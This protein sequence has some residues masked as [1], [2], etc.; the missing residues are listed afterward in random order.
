MLIGGNGPAGKVLASLL[1]G[2]CVRRMWLA[3]HAKPW[4]SLQP[5]LK[6]LEEN[7][8]VEYLGPCGFIVGSASRPSARQERSLELVF[9]IFCFCWN[10]VCSHRSLQRSL[11][12]RIECAR[13][14][15]SVLLLRSDRLLTLTHDVILVSLV[16][17][18]IPSRISSMV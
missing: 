6:I 14:F 18:R 9:A 5:Y 16:S 15:R 11:R 7:G 3:V 1:R 17:H 13:L 4:R 2:S 10:A 12:R 8:A